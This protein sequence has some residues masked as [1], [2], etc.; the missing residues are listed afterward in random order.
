MPI[1][2]LPRCLEY[3]RR[4]CIRHGVKHSRQGKGRPL[5]NKH[6]DSDAALSKA[7]SP[8]LAFPRRTQRKRGK[9]EQPELLTETKNTGTTSK[10]LAK[11]TEV[12]FFVL[13]SMS[14][15]WMTFVVRN[16]SGLSVPTFVI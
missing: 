16:K 5:R 7:S 4:G 15:L 13:E 3:A 10:G 11:A 2:R 8:D 6:V 14:M 1:Y 9:R 12:V